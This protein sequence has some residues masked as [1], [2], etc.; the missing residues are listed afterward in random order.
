LHDPLL[1]FAGAQI[2]S[3]PADR[4][5]RPLGIVATKVQGNID[6]HTRV[7]NQLDEGRLF[8]GKETG[9][10]Q[11]P[12][13]GVL[14]KQNANTAR[15]ADADADLNTFRKKYGPN[16]EPH[17]NLTKEIMKRCNPARN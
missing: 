9:L 17:V 12:L 3:N 4:P 13:F 8:E 1:V 10:T 11:P 2:V 7:M 14:I 5:I 15:G 16:Y 6:L